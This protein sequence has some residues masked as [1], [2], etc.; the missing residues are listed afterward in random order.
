MCYTPYNEIPHEKIVS[1]PMNDDLKLLI[2][3][4]HDKEKQITNDLFDEVYEH[5]LD[6]LVSTLA[7]MNDGDLSRVLS[8]I[9]KEVKIEKSRLETE[10]K[11]NKKN[12]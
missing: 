4:G 9:V 2:K 10:S 7:T 8:H 1:L 3:I 5:G 6:P 11:K 12:V